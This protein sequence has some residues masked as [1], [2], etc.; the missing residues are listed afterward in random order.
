M[1]AVLSLPSE[2][3]KVELPSDRKT[4]YLQVKAREGDTFNF[5]FSTDEKKWQTVGEKITYGNLEGAR[6]A[7]VYNGKTANAG[8]RFD[9]IKVE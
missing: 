1:L 6:L 2:I 3:S 4:I 9:W 5:A 7:L 8:A